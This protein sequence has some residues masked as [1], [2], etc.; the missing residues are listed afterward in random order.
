MKLVT[1]TRSLEKRFGLKKAIKML[2]DAGFD[3]YDCSLGYSMSKGEFS[4]DDAIEK[5]REIKEYSDKLGIPCAQTHTPSHASDIKGIKY[6]LAGIETEKKAVEIMELMEQD[7]KEHDI[8]EDVVMIEKSSIS[9][10]LKQKLKDEIIEYEKKK[11][12]NFLIT[13][14]RGIIK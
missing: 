9:E 7:Y 5:A 10:E 13:Q 11:K 12:Q 4:G 2:K 14:G 1:M 6:F 3:A 8:D